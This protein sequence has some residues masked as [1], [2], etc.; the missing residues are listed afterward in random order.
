M[1]ILNK[2]KGLVLDIVNK[3]KV[4]NDFP[5]NSNKFLYQKIRNQG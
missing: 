4:C 3:L 5:E 2:K 1:G